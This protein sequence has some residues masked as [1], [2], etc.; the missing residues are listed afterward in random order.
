M[1]LLTKEQI[2]EKQD[3]RTETIAVPEWGGDVRVRGLTA[4]ERSR[5]AQDATRKSNGKDY[6]DWLR[7]QTDTFIKG[8]VEPEFDV[9][10]ANA[11]AAKSSG[12]LQR[13]VAA[14]SRLSGIDED[15]IEEMRKNSET[16]PVG[17]S[18]S[19]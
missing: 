6:T 4:R 14:I 12:A 8:V 5:I 16:S 7:A 10:D 3:I 19:S 18:S 1:A 9:N 13:V 2:L 15:E 11:L 17:S